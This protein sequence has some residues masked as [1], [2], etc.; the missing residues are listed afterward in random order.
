PGHGG[1]P[2]G[3]GRHRSGHFLA[4]PTVARHRRRPAHLRPPPAA[5]ATPVSAHHRVVP[6]DK[7]P[8]TR[9]AHPRAPRITRPPGRAPSPGPG[10]PSTPPPPAT[11]GGRQNNGRLAGTPTRRGKRP[12][13]GWATTKLR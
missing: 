3:A 1:R 6:P 5:W 7:R 12:G 11:P 9:S 10:A 4:M 13:H 2:A 8:T